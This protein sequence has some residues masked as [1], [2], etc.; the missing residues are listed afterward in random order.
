MSNTDDKK[1]SLAV[2]ALLGVAIVLLAIMYFTPIWWV[3]LKAPNYPPE[4]FPDG[5]RIHFHFN[6][7]FNGCSLVESKEV[8]IEEALNCVHEMDTINHYVG[9]YPI[10]SGG[11]IERALSQFLVAFLGVMLISFAFRN[12]KIRAQVMAVGFGAIAAWMYMAMYTDGGVMTL[13]DGYRAALQSSL[14]LDV[15][16]IQHWSGIEAITESYRDTLGIYFR[17]EEIIEGKVE[18]LKLWT[19]GIVIAL[20]A[21]MLIL[22]VGAYF[23]SL[24]YWLLIGVPILLPVFFV[25]DYAAWLWYFGH[26]LN[27]MGAFAVKPFMPTVFGQ[28]KVAQFSTHSYPHI[29]Y[30]LMMAMS[31]ILVVVAMIRKKQIQNEGG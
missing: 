20:V 22:I 19:N 26:T 14:D 30:F 12:K 16:D 3:S 10:A 31:A 17:Q 5:I 2:N 24:F 28:G 9:M 7:V 13:S 6:G 8:Q 29:G 1:R 4:A 25:I 27:T 11:P 15:E 21:A 23:S 18:T